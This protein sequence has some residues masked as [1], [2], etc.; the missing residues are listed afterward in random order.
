M[1][2]EMFAG[3]EGEADAGIV[4]WVCRG[5]NVDIVEQKQGGLK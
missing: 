1:A 2:G 4:L 3:S 5:S